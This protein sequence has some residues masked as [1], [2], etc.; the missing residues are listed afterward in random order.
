MSSDFVIY[1]TLFCRITVILLGNKQV[2]IIYIY[3]YFI[4]IL[5]NYIIPTAQGQMKGE[6]YKRYYKVYS[7]NTKE[8][9][10]YIWIK[11]YQK[12]N[13]NKRLGKYSKKN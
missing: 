3:F 4:F 1:I 5:F 7:N 11:I 9:S 13:L 8:T 2:K 10:V 6:K 12:L